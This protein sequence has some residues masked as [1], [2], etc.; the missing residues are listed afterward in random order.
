MF[1]RLWLLDEPRT[2]EDA[3]A[4]EPR[5]LPRAAGAEWTMLEERTLAYNDSATITRTFT[6][7]TAADAAA[8]QFPVRLAAVGKLSPRTADPDPTIPSI[9]LKEWTEEGTALWDATRS[10][11]AQR[12]EKIVSDAAA[13][14]GPRSQR[15]RMELQIEVSSTP[16]P[17]ATPAAAQPA[18]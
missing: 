10:R 1:E 16:V 14:L 15:S 8:A 7:E 17:P 18:Q 5:W 3:A 6:R 12:R 4:E 2:G 11:V 13:T 9:S